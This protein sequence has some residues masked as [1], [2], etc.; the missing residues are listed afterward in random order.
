MNKNLHIFLNTFIS[1]LLLKKGKK[2]K[3]KIKK[4]IA[5]NYTEGTR[6]KTKSISHGWLETWKLKD[7]R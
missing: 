3:K 1:S 5:R 7:A 4:N 6:G 2:I